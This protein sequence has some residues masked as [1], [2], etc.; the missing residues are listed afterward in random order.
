MSEPITI[1][2]REI[3]QQEHILQFIDHAVTFCDLLEGSQQLTAQQFA[4]QVSQ[5][6]ALL[7]AAALALPSIHPETDVIQGTSDTEDNKSLLQQINAKFKGTTAYWEVFNPYNVDDP[8][9][10]E[11]ALMGALDDDLLDIY[12]DLLKGFRIYGKGSSDQDLEAVWYWQ[13]S[14]NTHWGRH[15][16]SALRALHQLLSENLLEE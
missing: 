4:V 16:V 6:M 13:L 3:T 1:S 9:K 11:E 8:Y 15:L 2:R 10:Q 7:Y 5:T 14:F 12:S